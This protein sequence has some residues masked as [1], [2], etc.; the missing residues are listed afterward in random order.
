MCFYIHIYIYSLAFGC[1]CSYRYAGVTD[2]ARGKQKQKQRAQC[3]ASRAVLMWPRAETGTRVN[4]IDFPGRRRDGQGQ[5][6]KPRGHKM[7]PQ[8]RRLHGQGRKMNPEATKSS[9]W[10]RTDMTRNQEWKPGGAHRVSKAVLTGPR[11]KM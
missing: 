7:E 5:K 2:A 4:L 3:R 8:G 11:A 9:L 6:M 10:G 1:L